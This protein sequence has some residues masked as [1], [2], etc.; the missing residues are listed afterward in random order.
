MEGIKKQ[1]W[2]AC[3]ELSIKYIHAQCEKFSQSGVPSP[4]QLTSLIEIIDEFIFSWSS[5]GNNKSG[6]KRRSARLSNIQQYHEKK[7]TG[8]NSSKHIEGSHLIWTFQ[9]R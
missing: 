3:A 5:P 1:E 7:R 9:T 2:P 8:W 6:G 4:A